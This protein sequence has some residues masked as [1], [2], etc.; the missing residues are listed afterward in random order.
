MRATIVAGALAALVYGSTAGAQDP[1]APQ[2]EPDLGVEDDFGYEQ[3]DVGLMGEVPPAVE[4]EMVPVTPAPGVR[5]VEPALTSREAE[6][7]RGTGAFG[8]LV[9]TAPS[10]R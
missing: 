5:E 6:L 3:E 2:Q 7:L 4:V 8:A 10:H 9:A 1:P